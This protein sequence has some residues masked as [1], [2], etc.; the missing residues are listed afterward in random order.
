MIENSGTPSQFAWTQFYESTANKLLVFKDKRSDLLVGIHNLANDL[1]FSGVNDQLSDK[2][3]V[4]MRDICPFTVMGLFN[5]NHTVDNRK[6]IAKA[7]GAFLGVSEDVPSSFDGVPILTAQNA[8][9]FP[10]EK[11]RGLNDIECLWEL[12]SVALQYSKHSSQENRQAFIKRYDNALKV[13]YSSWNIS[14]GLF[15]IRPWTFL[16]FDSSMRQFLQ[17]SLNYPVKDKRLDLPLTGQEYLEKVDSIRNKIEGGVWPF[18]SF[19]ELSLAAWTGKIPSTP[20]PSSAATPTVVGYQQKDIITDGS[21]LPL[22]ILNHMLARLRSKKNI[23]LQ[24]PPG[25]GKTWLAKR[26]AWALTGERA[27]ARVQAIQ[28]HATLSYEDFVCGWRPSGQGEL[29]LMDGPFL[30]CVSRANKEP[31]VP[32]VMVIEEINRGNPAQIFGELLT[33]L[34]ANKRTSEE[35]LPLCYQQEGQCR[36]IHLPANLYII[37]TMNIADRS[38]AIVDF[39]LRRRFAFF[40]LKPEFGPSWQTWMCAK[41]Q[42]PQGFIKRLGENVDNCNAFIAADASLGPQYAIGHSYFICENAQDSSPEEWLESVVETEIMPLLREYWFDSSQNVQ[43]ARELITQ[44]L[45]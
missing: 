8:W 1:K 37:G 13:K 19:P 26:L 30:E 42:M 34:E 23:I 38:L 5:K 20:P 15:W 41:T 11:E 22:P 16:A 33:L 12:F 35:Q 40:D 28:F 32:H 7:L 21:F 18:R 43:K 36:C 44:S 3:V 9:F 27:S 45:L 2:S 4:P 17:Q 6:K 25:T 39:A 24:G 31:E 10:Y 14:M 29:K